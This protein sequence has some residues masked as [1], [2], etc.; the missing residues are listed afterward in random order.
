MFSLTTDELI[1]LIGEKEVQ[2]YLAK[3]EIARTMAVLEK[4]TSGEPTEEASTEQDSS[5][6][7][8]N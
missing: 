1:Y 7:T 6:E 5:G 8:D 3:K 4:V 2:L